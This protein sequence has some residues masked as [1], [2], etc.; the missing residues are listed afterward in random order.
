MRDTEK[1]MQKKK[2]YTYFIFHSIFKL[3]KIIKLRFGEGG[4][5]VCVYFEHK[6]S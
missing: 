4:G 1:V 2:I 6:L 3:M 5:C